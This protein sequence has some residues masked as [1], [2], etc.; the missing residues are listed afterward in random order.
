M[1]FLV[2]SDNGKWHLATYTAYDAYE[3]P[4]GEF[5]N[6]REAIQCV[7]DKGEGLVKRYVVAFDKDDNIIYEDVDEIFVW[8][9]TPKILTPARKQ[10]LKTSEI[11][12]KKFIK[13]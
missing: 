2:E 4:Y 3:N 13:R 7:L 9:L 5:D 8:G 12:A 6:Q 10:L 1:K 11:K